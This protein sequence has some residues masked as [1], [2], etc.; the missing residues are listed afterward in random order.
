SATASSSLTV[1]FAAS[2]NCTVSGATVHI[3]GAGSCTITAS[4]AGNDNYSAA[5]DVPQLF[6]IAKANQTITFGV[7]ADKTFGD[8]DFSVGAT[9]SSTLTVSFIASGNCTVSGAT[10][11]IT[12]AGS[13]TITAQQAGDANYNPAADVPQL[14][15]IAKGTQ[16]I[17]FGVL[18]GKTFGDPDFD[19]SATASS[20]LAVSFAAS[21]N[22]TVGGATVHVTGA[23]SCTITAS[24]GGNENYNAAADV[25]QI[26]AIA[27]ANQTVTFGVLAGK[28]FGDADFDVS[29]TGGGSGNT[30]TFAASGNCTVSGST[31]H[32]TGGGSCTITA[33]QAG[34]DNY[35]AAPDVPQTFT[36][37]KANQTVTFGVLGGKTFREPDFCRSATASSTFAVS[38]AASGS[39]TVVGS[40]VHIA[41]AGSCNITAQQGGDGNFNAAPDVPQSF[42]IAKANQTITFGALADKTFLNPDFS[43]S[44]TASSTL[45]VTFGA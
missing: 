32:I 30:V 28:T 44:A 35:N 38:F 7:L 4:Q 29:A 45:A 31:V 11:H 43:L 20:S 40:T 15:S 23:G 19:V 42:T 27:K 26:F 1:T 5:P 39:C 3:T 37:A 34:N 21:G 17:T 8:P 33:S 36:I 12:G 16:T 22:C 18:A 2:G 24:Q 9:A 14:F 6:S 41:G 25:P 10:V 13:C